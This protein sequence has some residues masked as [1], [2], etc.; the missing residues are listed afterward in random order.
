MFLRGFGTANE[1]SW[2]RG[3]HNTRIFHQW[4]QEGRGKFGGADIAD[5]DLTGF[6]RMMDDE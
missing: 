3:Y 1:Y 2:R 4:V 5:L 6:D